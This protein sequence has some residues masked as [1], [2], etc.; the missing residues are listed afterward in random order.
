MPADQIS[1]SPPELIC[2]AG[3]QLFLSQIRKST[4]IMKF[5]PNVAENSGTRFGAPTVR[6]GLPL[7]RAES[8]SGHASPFG[9]GSSE[10]G[11]GQ[12][13][14]SCDEAGGVPRPCHIEKRSYD[15]IHNYFWS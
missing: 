14:G 12:L 7:R 11:N 15:L 10:L 4:C 8:D 2:Q 13:S 9:C 6:E 3:G 1:C 5:G